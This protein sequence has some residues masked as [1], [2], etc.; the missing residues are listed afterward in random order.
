RPLR[1]PTRTPRTT[2]SYRISVSWPSASAPER[3]RSD[4]PGDGRAAQPELLDAFLEL[5]RGEIRMLQG[6]RGEGHEAVV[7]RGARLRE[8]CVR[9]SRMPTEQHPHPDR[10]L[11]QSSRN[12]RTRTDRVLSSPREQGLYEGRGLG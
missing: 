6:D 4:A 3:E 11:R 10:F 9:A 5:F 12:T 7:V 1:P 2:S 8:L